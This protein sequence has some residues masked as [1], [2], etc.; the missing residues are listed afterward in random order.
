M[1]KV[2]EDWRT[3]A[4]LKSTRTLGNAIASW[5]AAALCRFDSEQAYL[6]QTIVKESAAAKMVITASGASKRR[7]TG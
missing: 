3:V 1:G 6:K 7:I 5:F 2:P 4:A